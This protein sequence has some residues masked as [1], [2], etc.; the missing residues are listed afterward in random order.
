[1]LL[2]SPLRGLHHVRGACAHCASACDCGGDGGWGR[3]ARGGW[4]D[5]GR[6]LRIRLSEWGGSH[7]HCASACGCGGDGA[8]AAPHE[9]MAGRCCESERKRLQRSQGVGVDELGW[10][11]GFVWANF[12]G[13]LASWAQCSIVRFFSVNREL[14]G[15]FRFLG[16]RNRFFQFWFLRFRFPVL[17]VRFPVL[18]FLCPALALTSEPSGISIPTTSRATRH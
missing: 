13:L 5:G 7:A 17:S 16:I 2:S 11:L 10:E 18:G 4:P 9:G 15:V 6:L 12:V 1:M 8:G 3:A 14:T